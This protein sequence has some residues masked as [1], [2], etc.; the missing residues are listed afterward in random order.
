MMDRPPNLLLPC[1]RRLS[2]LQPSPSF[3]ATPRVLEQARRLAP[4]G[5]DGDRCLGGGSAVRRAA[6]DFGGEGR[7][8]RGFGGRRRKLASTSCA[9]G[10]MAGLRSAWLELGPRPRVP[11]LSVFITE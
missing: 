8:P 10:G 3:M 2:L 5:G 7:P 9:F 6:M 11:F 1:G 4:R